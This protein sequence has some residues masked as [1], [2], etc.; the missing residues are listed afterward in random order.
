MCDYVK[1]KDSCSLLQ[2]RRND[3]ECGNVGEPVLDE[4]T[5]KSSQISPD[6]YI[7]GRGYSPST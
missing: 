6:I 1:E 7:M 3:F 5:D 4:R 2:R